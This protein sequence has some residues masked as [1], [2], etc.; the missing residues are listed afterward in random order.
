VLEEQRPT[1]RQMTQLADAMQVVSLRDKQ[2]QFE[3]SQ[4]AKKFDEKG[5]NRQNIKKLQ[6]KHDSFKLWSIML[7][8]NMF[9]IQNESFFDILLQ[10]SRMK[11]KLMHL[12]K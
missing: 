12:S 3:E 5:T 1:K 11:S 10:L 8:V 4:P 6:L 9:I 2:K 7:V